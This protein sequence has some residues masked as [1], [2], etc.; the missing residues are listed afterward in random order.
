MGN[1]GTNPWGF[2]INNKYFNHLEVVFMLRTNGSIRGTAN[3]LYGE[4]YANIQ[5]LAEVRTA[6][7]LAVKGKDVTTGIE[8]VSKVLGAIAVTITAA[9]YEGVSF[10]KFLDTVSAAGETLTAVKVTVKSKLKDTRKFKA[11]KVIDIDDNFV[12]EVGKFYLDSV[13]SMFYQDMANDNIAELN[14]KLDAIC[15]EAGIP[16]KIAFA[17]GVDNGGMIVSISDDK[18]VFNAT[19]AAAFRVSE[20]ALMQGGDAYNDL[21]ATKSA[22]NFVAAVKAAQTTPLI[23]KARIDVVNYFTEIKPRKKVAKLIRDNYHKQAKYLTSAG[24]G[25]VAAVYEDKK[26]FGIVEKKESGELV[27]VLSAFD[28]DT[29]ASVDVDIKTLI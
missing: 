12:L 8:T 26:V 4:A 10:P 6:E 22:E 14:A 23:V 15:E 21:V 18:V 3:A 20:Y 28:T 16:S 13:T 24:V 9:N 27:T 7:V 11:S 17:C 5:K 1:L 19:L 29:C 25:Y 2:C